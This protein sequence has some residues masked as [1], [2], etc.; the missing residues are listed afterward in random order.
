M[1]KASPY[2]I[3]SL[4]FFPMSLYQTYAI[5]HFNRTLPTFKT[6]RIAFTDLDLRLA[7]G[8]PTYVQYFFVIPFRTSKS[9]QQNKIIRCPHL[10]SLPFFPILLSPQSNFVT[11]LLTVSSRDIKVFWVLQVCVR[12]RSY[13]EHRNTFNNDHEARMGRNINTAAFYLILSVHFQ[14]LTIL[15]RK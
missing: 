14:T 2:C 8:I 9:G 15:C 3:L 1:Q 4:L 6:R 7:L 13:F 12:H 5:R 11:F 10:L